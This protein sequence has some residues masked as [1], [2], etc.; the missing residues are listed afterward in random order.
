MLGAVY[1]RR[2]VSFLS[3]ERQTAVEDAMR[4]HEGQ[5][6]QADGLELVEAWDKYVQFQCARCWVEEGFSYGAVSLVQC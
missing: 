2:Q 6:E 1:D 5:V 3:T 4:S